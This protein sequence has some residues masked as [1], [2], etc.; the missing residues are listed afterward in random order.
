[1]NSIETKELLECYKMVLDYLKKLD[2][3]KV[4]VEKGI[5]DVK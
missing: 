3:K 2:D 4:E 1:M 5:E